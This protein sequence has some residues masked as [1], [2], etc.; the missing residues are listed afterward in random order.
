[1]VFKIKTD[2]RAEGDITDA[3]DYY[4]KI[5]AELGDRFLSELYDIFDQLSQNPYLYSL[6]SANSASNFRDVNLPS[7]PY[8][9]VYETIESS[10]FV[11]SVMHT[12]HEPFNP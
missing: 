7:F 1:M 2:F 5:N 11:T 3:V 10:V 12:K 9:V 8:V 6:I 4:D